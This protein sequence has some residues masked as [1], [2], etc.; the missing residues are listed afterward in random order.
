MTP[1][2]DGGHYLF[3]KSHGVYE[4]SIYSSYIEDGYIYPN[5]GP[6]AIDRDGYFSGRWTVIPQGCAPFEF[7]EIRQSSSTGTLGRLFDVSNPRTKPSQVERLARMH[8]LGDALRVEVSYEIPD[9]EPLKLID[10]ESAWYGYT[11]EHIVRDHDP[12]KSWPGEDWRERESIQL[13]AYR[14]GVTYRVLEVLNGGWEL[15]VHNWPKA[16]EKVLVPDRDRTI[17]DDV[18]WEPYWLFSETD[19][20]IPKADGEGTGKSKNG[21]IV[22][23]YQECRFDSAYMGMGWGYEVGDEV[24]IIGRGT[25][26]C[27]G[28]S[29][30]SIEGYT[31]WLADEKF[32]RTY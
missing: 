24:D 13:I 5:L 19:A 17:Y 23:V 12:Y 14:H 20:V 9:G 4:N 15:G 8:C 28:W 18:N 31:G 27:A 21:L 3:W 25:G 6:R 22:L 26:P 29:V 30:I 7:E 16:G 1:R 11:K 10:L 32:E 2:D